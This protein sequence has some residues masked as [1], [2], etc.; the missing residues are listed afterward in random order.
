METTT[1]TY[2]IEY[3]FETAKGIF[4]SIIVERELPV[5]LIE[6]LTPLDDLV[7]ILDLDVYSLDCDGDICDAWLNIAITDENGNDLLLAQI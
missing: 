3:A 2:T 4:D 1:E 7:T 6:N 5:E